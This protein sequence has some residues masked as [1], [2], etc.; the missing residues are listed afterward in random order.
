MSLVL[1]NGFK[2]LLLSS[3]VNIKFEL[4]VKSFQDLINKPK[5][6]I[7]C[8]IYT[9]NKSFEKAIELPEFS[10]LKGRVLQRDFYDQT[11]IDKLRTGQEV[12][13]CNKHVY[14]IKLFILTSI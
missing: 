11:M 9:Y 14:F 13:L 1:S 8:D 4:E 12:L 6:E 10:K 5:V 2:G 7:Y 3:Y